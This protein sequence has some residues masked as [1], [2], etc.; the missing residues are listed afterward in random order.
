MLTCWYLQ[1]PHGVLQLRPSPSNTPCNAFRL[2]WALPTSHDPSNPTP[3]LTTLLKTINSVC[4]V[5]RPYADRPILNRHRDLQHQRSRYLSLPILLP[6][7]QALLDPHLPR[8]SRT[9]ASTKDAV[10][11]QMGYLPT[12]SRIRTPP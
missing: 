4:R 12:D 11:L 8:R 7:P 9:P 3:L 10:L 5:H 6:L 1:V 2:R